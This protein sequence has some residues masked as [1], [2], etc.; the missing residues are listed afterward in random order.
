MIF[1]GMFFETMMTLVVYGAY[2]FV[3][4][5]TLWMV[6]D[7]GKQDRF[8]WMILILGIPFVGSTVYFFTEKKHEYAKAEP[9]H[10]HDTETEEQHE[11]SPRKRKARKHVVKHDESLSETETQNNDTVEP[12]TQELKSSETSNVKEEETSPHPEAK[13]S[14]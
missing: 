8:W 3:I 4:S 11:T 5:F 10:V 9:H 14:V 12:E 13:V 1:F 6:V 2:I 7:A